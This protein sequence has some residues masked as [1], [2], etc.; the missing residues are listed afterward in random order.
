MKYLPLSRVSPRTR[1]PVDGFVI[2][3]RALGA[4]LPSASVTKPPMAPVVVP[5]AIAV[6]APKN[7]AAIA[8][9]VLVK[10]R[11]C[12]WEPGRLESFCSLTRSYFDIDDRLAEQ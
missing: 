2:S 1:K 4:G 6:V 9:I 10:R 8:T 11:V 5:W 3:M 12:M 7:N